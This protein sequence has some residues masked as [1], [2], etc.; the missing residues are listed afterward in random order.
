M[1][2]L[3][4][5]AGFQLAWFA[6]VVGVEQRQEALA[7]TFGLMLGLIHLYFSPVRGCD[8]RLAGWSLAVGILTDSLLQLASVIQFNGVSMGNL[9][10]YWLWIIWVLFGLTLNSSLAFLKTRSLYISAAL[11]AVFGPLSY[12]GGAQ[13]GAASTSI[14]HTQIVQLALIWMIILPLLVQSARRLSPAPA[15][16]PNS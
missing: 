10:P 14:S 11:G 8:I 13:L 3:L 1:R 5:A 15:Q 2:K 7:I 6:C 12:L 16:V 4:N 9:S